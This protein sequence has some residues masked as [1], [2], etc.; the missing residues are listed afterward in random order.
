MAKKMQDVIQFAQC[1]GCKASTVCLVCPLL[2]SAYEGL[3][4]TD[5][6]RV[7]EGVML[8]CQQTH[9]IKFLPHIRNFA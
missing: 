4:R 2:S 7:L 9:H 8:C 1:S 3:N 5:K 6:E